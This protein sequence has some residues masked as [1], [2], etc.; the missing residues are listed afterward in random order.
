VNP[1]GRLNPHE[2]I[3]SG[4]LILQGASSSISNFKSQF[5]I[6]L[7]PSNSSESVHHTHRDQPFPSMKSGKPY[8]RALP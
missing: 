7:H 8:H 3:G 2:Q 6:L 1:C 4:E 5:Q